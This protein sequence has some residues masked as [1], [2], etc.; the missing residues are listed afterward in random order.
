MLS[1]SAS[2]ID[3]GQF[4]VDHLLERESRIAQHGLRTR[5]RLLQQRSDFRGPQVVSGFSEAPGREEQ[6]FVHQAFQPPPLFPNHGAVLLHL[7]R[8]FDHAVDN[9]FRGR[10]DHR[11]GSAELMR[12]AGHKFHLQLGQPFGAPRHGEEQH[13]RP[14]QQPQQAEADG[15]VPP[16]PSR[17]VH[18][19]RSRGVPHDQLPLF[20]VSGH[21]Q[22]RMAPSPGL[23]RDRIEEI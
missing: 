18:V 19:D 9:I 3:E 21:L 1:A 17:H 20:A 15:Q 5:Q 10:V 22:W 2:A 4:R 6:D 11:Q 12:N 14:R 23:L 7:R 13:R 8:S 16:A